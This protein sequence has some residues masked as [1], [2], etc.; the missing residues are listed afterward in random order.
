MGNFTTSAGSVSI[1]ITNPVRALLFLTSLAGQSHFRLD[2]RQV[3]AAGE[4]V[5]L[6]TSITDI[7]V[8]ITGY[9]FLATPEAALLPA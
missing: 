9:E 6:S 2:L 1:R 7:S 8:L 4:E 3:V 5:D